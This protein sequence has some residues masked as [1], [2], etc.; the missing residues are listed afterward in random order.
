MRVNMPTAHEITRQSAELV[1]AGPF[2]EATREIGIDAGHRVMHH[3]SKCR[4]LHGHRYTVQATIRGPLIGDGSSE[5]MV[6]DFGFLKDIMMEEIDAPCDHGTII[7]VNDI[8]MMQALISD[9]HLDGVSDVVRGTGLGVNG[10]VHQG[11]LGK[12]YVVRFIP[13]AENLA[14]HWFERIQAAMPPP[15]TTRLHRVRVWETPNCFADY[16]ST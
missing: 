7:C 4:S 14:R 10:Y 5:G 3:H 13:T 1:I 12:V 15:N 11:P 8:I 9:E 16:P 6:M 2:F